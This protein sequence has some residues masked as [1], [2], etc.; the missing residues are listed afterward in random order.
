[1][2]RFARLEFENSRRGSQPTGRAALRDEHYW[3]DQADQQRRSGH[4]ENALRCYTRALENDNVLV[5][6]WLGQAQMLILLDEAPEADLWCRQALN[7]FPGHGDLSAA[8]AQAL[9]RS[10]QRQQAMALCDVAMAAAGQSAYRWQVRGEVL[11]AGDGR[12]AMH[13][14]EQAAL[15]CA[16]WLTQLETALILLHW[17]R[18]PQ[19]LAYARS[20]THAAPDA[21]YAWLV[22][23]RAE[24]QLGSLQESRTSLTR[25]L[26][27]CP[28]HIGALHGIAQLERSAWWPW[29]WLRPWRTSE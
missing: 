21:G 17:R 14:F 3:R 19:A 13:C 29:S 24:A 4:Y 12:S 9:C 10:G 26:E 1:M 28:G 18:Y 8:R 6:G 27:L 22:R 20:A 16:D 7:L 11:L 5:A 25:C 15:A 2:S 23:G